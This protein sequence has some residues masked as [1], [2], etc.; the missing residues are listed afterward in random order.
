MKTEL[1]Q[2]EEIIKE[3]KANHSVGITNVG[4][5]LYL[6]NIRIVF[7]TNALNWMQ[8]HNFSLLLKDIS[9]FGK[10]NTLFIIPNSIFI[11]SKEGKEDKFVVFGRDKWLKDIG[12]RVACI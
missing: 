11:K 4:G 9:S 12:E 10:R 8:K 5:T 2:G 1:M 3:G 6:T 7:E